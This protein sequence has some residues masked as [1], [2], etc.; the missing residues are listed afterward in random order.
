M[1]SRDP[2]ERP[3][4]RERGSEPGDEGMRDTLGICAGRRLDRRGELVAATH[5]EYD[6]RLIQAPG[7]GR[8]RREDPMSVFEGNLPRRQE[9]PRGADPPQADLEVGLARG[10]R[11]E[12][13]DRVA[14]GNRTRGRRWPGAASAG[15]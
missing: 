4:S 5:D 9:Q 7:Q 11:L 10:G 13:P 14:S 2:P 12:E 3:R 6:R 8:G 1:D 15:R